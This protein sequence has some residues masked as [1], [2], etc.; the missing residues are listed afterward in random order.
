MNNTKRV[1]PLEHTVRLAADSYANIAPCCHFDP[2][3]SISV[4]EEMHVQCLHVVILTCNKSLQTQSAGATCVEITPDFSFTEPYR[5]IRYSSPRL[6]GIVQFF[7][8]LNF[9]KNT[10]FAETKSISATC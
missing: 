2:Y 1:D 5:N 7:L 10:D 4:R 9:K 6:L 8:L 3:S